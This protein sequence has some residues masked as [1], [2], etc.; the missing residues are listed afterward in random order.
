MHGIL[1]Q[2]EDVTELQPV[3]DAH[4]TVMKFKFHGIYIDLLCAS[5]SLLVVPAVSFLLYVSPS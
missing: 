4:V 2:T 1:A 3:P 5:V